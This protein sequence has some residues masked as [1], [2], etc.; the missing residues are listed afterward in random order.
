MATLRIPGLLLRGDWVPPVRIYE[1]KSVLS[2]TDIILSER[3]SIFPGYYASQFDLSLAQDLEEPVNAQ[4]ALVSKDYDA[5]FLLFTE[6]SRDADLASLVAKLE[7]AHLHPFGPREA[8]YLAGQTK[9][10]DFDRVHV[11]L[12]EEPKFVVITDDPRHRWEE[13]LAEAGVQA[14]V[15]IVEPFKYE[16]GYVL[17]VN[18]YNPAYA[19]AKVIATCNEHPIAPN[20]L[21]VV[22]KDPNYAPQ[23]GHISIKYENSA[24]Q[25]QLYE[26]DGEWLMLSGDSFT[27]ES[28][29]LEIVEGAD[30]TLLMRK[31][32]KEG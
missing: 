1:G 8:G 22:W 16:D 20:F 23:S 15:M 7:I 17:R 13:A 21:E 31:S 30:G 26:S 12:R 11:L 28:P 14:E 19:T 5:W 25:W 29:T 32:V 24:I 6:S 4:I 27:L 18:G 10:L 2:L 9:E 3:E